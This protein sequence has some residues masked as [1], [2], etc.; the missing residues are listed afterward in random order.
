MTLVLED[1][2]LVAQPCD[3]PNGQREVD[4]TTVPPQFPCAGEC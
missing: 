1:H 3:R 4:P 2:Q